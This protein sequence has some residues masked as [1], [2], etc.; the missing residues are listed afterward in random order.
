MLELTFPA[1][2]EVHVLGAH[3]DDIAIGAG[4]TLAMIVRR[5]PGVRVRALVLTGAGTERE[6]EE[7]DALAA[8][9]G[10]A[11]LSVEVLSFPDGRVP[12]SWLEAKQAVHAFAKGGA[13]DLVIGPQPGDAHQDHRALAEFL[14]QAYR[15]TT[16]LG[17]EIVKWEADL[18]TPSLFVPL[19][20][21]DLARKLDVLATCYPSQSDKGWYDEELFRGLARI[22]G[23]HAGARWAEAFVAPAV[24]V[25]F[26][27]KEN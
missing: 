7:R 3:C 14:P 22:R 27:D 25:S 11:E 8:L 21:A 23:V 6:A 9:C 15:G 16:I 13:A 12:A 10:G 24:T 4:A 20:A 17:Y 5:N 1:L 26:A 18:P 19:E 2:G